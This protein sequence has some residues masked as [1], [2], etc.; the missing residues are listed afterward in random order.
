ME[1][2]KKNDSFTEPGGQAVPETVGRRKKRRWVWGSGGVLGMA[3]LAAV[4]WQVW[5]EEAY[6]E[7][8]YEME[9]YP[10]LI[11]HFWDGNDACYRMEYDHFAGL[12]RD[13]KRVN[14]DHH[15]SDFVRGG[16][17][18]NGGTTRLGENLGMVQTWVRSGEE[19]IE[20]AVFLPVKTDDL[21]SRMKYD[22]PNHCCVDL[23]I[24]PMDLTGCW[25]KPSHVQYVSGCGGYK[26]EDYW[27]A[28]GSFGDGDG[29]PA[30]TGTAVLWY[31]N[32]ALSYRG[33]V[34]WKC[35]RPQRG[36][37]EQVV[38]A[39]GDEYKGDPK[40]PNRC[41]I[42]PTADLMSEDRAVFERALRTLRECGWDDGS[43]KK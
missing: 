7:R 17:S 9:G 36:C 22:G 20:P 31:K 18:T 2:E 15:E 30:G 3:L 13:G 39:C 33:A 1:T 35:Y 38:F 34:T 10:V 32:S 40:A 19:T 4:V 14:L 5:G 11:P 8:L 41:Y 26:M 43:E 6:T 42:P 27:I 24:T 25:I 37:R 21:V 12:S 29:L 16:V 28:Y 23:D